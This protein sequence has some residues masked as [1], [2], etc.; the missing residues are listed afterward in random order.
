[1]ADAVQEVREIDGVPTIYRWNG[2]DVKVKIPLDSEPIKTFQEG[3]KTIMEI[4]GKRY[5][6]TPTSDNPPRVYVWAEHHAYGNTYD[7]FGHFMGQANF[8]RQRGIGRVIHEFFG[9]F[10]Y[11]PSTQTYSKR[12]KAPSMERSSPVSAEDF[13]NDVNNTC[14]WDHVLERKLYQDLAGILGF[15]I[16]GSD[17]DTERPD[18]VERETEQFEVFDEYK[19]TPE[20]PVLAVAGAAHCR[21]VSHLT[22]LLQERGVDAAIIRDPEI[23]AECEAEVKEKSHWRYPWEALA[24][25]A[26]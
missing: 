15:E 5:E 10:I 13:R 6:V 19:G 17:M 26:V 24:E 4:L 16:V 21:D 14:R 25:S 20:K 22:R 12:P 8:I 7:K 23:T 3:G 18:Y 9:D 2:W 1:M 11:D